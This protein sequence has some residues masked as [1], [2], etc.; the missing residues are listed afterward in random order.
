MFARPE[1]GH[2]WL[3]ERQRAALEALEK[4]APL[5][6]LL[7]QHSTGKT[8]LLRH[9]ASVQDVVLHCRGPRENASA[10]LSQLLLEA[11]LTPLGLPETDQRNLLTLFVRERRSQ[12]RRVVVAVDDADL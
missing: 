4:P 10:V 9:W 8:T 11:Q 6:V 12:G 7:G 1:A 5:R 2:I 3:G